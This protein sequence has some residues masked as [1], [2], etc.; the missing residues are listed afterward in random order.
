M[1][2]HLVL[3]VALTSLSTSPIWVRVAH[4]PLVTIGLWRLLLAGTLTVLWILL[5]NERPLSKLQLAMLSPWAWG[6]GILFFLH[7]WTYMEAVQTTSVSH[8]VLIF[9]S[10][11]IFTA[12]GSLF[13]FKDRFYPRFFLVYGLAI[14]GIVLLFRDHPEGSV[15]TLHGDLS[16][17]ISAALHAAY[18]LCGKKSR[19]NLD[20]SQFTAVLYLS[21][22]FFFLL[23]ALGAKEPLVHDT[24]GFNIAIFGLILFPTFL[25]HTLYAYLLKTMN[26]NFLSCSKL[27][28]PALSTLLAF[29]LFK[30]EIG[31]SDIFAYAFIAAAVLILFRPLHL[32]KG[33]F[34]LG[35]SS[36]GVE[37]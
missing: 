29:L 3:L 8:M 7:L 5:R 16:A 20:N 14:T 13:F 24:M 2:P 11:P 4:A 25:G 36:Q 37:K 27:L 22:G 1:T 19:E 21:S 23:W 34:R 33:S 18:T 30:E 35:S 12:I 6:T 28:E 10:A 9:S 32:R 15:S 26:I 31:A 17:L